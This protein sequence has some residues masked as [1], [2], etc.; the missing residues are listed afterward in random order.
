MRIGNM[1]FTFRTRVQDYIDGTATAKA[2]AKKVRGKAKPKAAKAANSV[3]DKL[4]QPKAKS[5]STSASSSSTIAPP[6]STPSSTSGSTE[7]PRVLNF[8]LCTHG[9]A[10]VFRDAS[11]CVSIANDASVPNDSSFVHTV[12]RLRCLQCLQCQLLLV[13]TPTT[14]LQS[15]RQQHRWEGACQAAGTA[16]RRVAA[17]TQNV[18]STTSC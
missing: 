9:H 11:V 10:C 4:L 1:L 3:I 15:T 17:A 14:L 2:A 8:E 18:G 12:M 6:P 13:A 16:C 7:V 5:G